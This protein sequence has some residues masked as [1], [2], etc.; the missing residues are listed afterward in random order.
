[1]IS[2]G[3]FDPA[4]L[5]SQPSAHYLDPAR[6]RIIPLQDVAVDAGTCGTFGPIPAEPASQDVIVV[7]RNGKFFFVR[8]HN[9]Q[10]FPGVRVEP[11]CELKSLRVTGHGGDGVVNIQ[12][13]TE[14]V[15]TIGHLTF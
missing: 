11:E 10:E 6:T 7:S 4:R 5:L 3:V 2:G 1:V 15:A 13:P 8:R 12:S 14:F 9:V